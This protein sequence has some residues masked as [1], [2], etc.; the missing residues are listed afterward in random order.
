[1]AK[2]VETRA[3]TESDNG[4]NMGQICFLEVPKHPKNLF[5]ELPTPRN[6]GVVVLLGSTVRLFTVGGSGYTG[7]RVP[8]YYAVCILGKRGLGPSGATCR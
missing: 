7:L 5:F 6:P 2:P 8:Y 1:M 4:A 3:E